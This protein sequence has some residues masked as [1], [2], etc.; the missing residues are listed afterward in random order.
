MLDNMLEIMTPNFKQNFVKGENIDL[1]IKKN[2][3]VI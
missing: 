1:G 3:I 2:A